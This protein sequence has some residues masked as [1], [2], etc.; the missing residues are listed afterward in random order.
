MRLWSMES[1]ILNQDDLRT[2]AVMKWETAFMG[3]KRLVLS[4]V[5]SR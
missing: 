1:E 2:H 4:G 5:A 3:N